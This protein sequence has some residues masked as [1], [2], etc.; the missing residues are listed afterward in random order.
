MRRNV[1]GEL[2]RRLVAAA[3]EWESAFGN[4]PSITSAL[5]EY[6]AAI[7]VGCSPEEYSSSMRGV[8]AVQKGFDFKR[9]TIRYQVK[10][11]RPS[12]KPGSFVTLVAKA[13]NYDWDFLIWVLYNPKYEV[14]EAWMWDVVAYKEA[15]DSIK[16][17]R[18][19]HY[20]LGKSLVVPGGPALADLLKVPDL[21]CSVAEE[22]L[23]G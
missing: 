19:K 18:P 23:N 12:G 9:G 8:T 17:L 5:S 16:T 2:R 20:R 3:L 11:N 15:F 10:A 4:A 7:L 21:S 6:D 22:A 13:A 14:Q 1:L